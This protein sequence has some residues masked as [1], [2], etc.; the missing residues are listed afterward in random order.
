[1]PFSFHGHDIFWI[2]YAPFKFITQ[3]AW[4]PYLH[5][6]QNFPGLHYTYYA[7]FLF[8]IISLFLFLFQP[9][10]PDLSR[11]YSVFET[12]NYTFTGNTIH[13]ASIFSGMQ[14][15][16]T[17]FIFKLP[18]LIFDFSIGA[19]ILSLLKSRPKERI[20]AYIIWMLNPFILHSC[21]AIGQVDIIVTFLVMA[22]LYCIYL[23]KK[24]TACV[25]LTLGVLTKTMPIL[26][27][28]FAIILLA[29]SFREG[30]K[31]SIFSAVTFLTLIIPFM[32]SSGNLVFNSFFFFGTGSSSLRQVFFMISYALLSF[33]YIFTR[34]K[35]PA[36]FDFI[37][38][39]FI[40]ILLLFYAFYVVTLRYFI[41]ITPLLIYISMKNKKFWWYG[42]VFLIALF[43][44]KN[45]DTTVQWGLFSP[46]YPEFFSGLPIMDSFLNLKIDVRII[47]KLMYRVFF[48][49]SLIMCAHLLYYNRK[50]FNFQ[51]F[52]PWQKSA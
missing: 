13:Y 42:L 38:S 40:I 10:L 11:L 35:G 6:S 52:M 47:H 15:F 44:L 49:A 30:V 23:R 7:P 45:F 32:I 34:K 50:N 48:A 43:E 5:L 4:D 24:K 12:W 22:A 25:I 2:Y 31:L 18:F 26:L 27:I 20:A 3:G 28:P 1:M 8:F 39:A 21:Y 33:F 14:L 9:L 19:I 36:D 41:V 16:R 37:V 29:D 46:L 17:L 51:K